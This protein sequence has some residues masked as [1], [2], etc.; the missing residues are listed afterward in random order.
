[1][2]WHANGRVK[3]SGAFA[4]RPDGRSVPHGTWSFWNDRGRIQGRAQYEQGRAGCFVVWDDS[5]EMQTF[6]SK[7]GARSSS[8]CEVAED[9]DASATALQ[10][11]PSVRF[12]EREPRFAL[13][14]GSMR[15]FNKMPVRAD[16][17]MVSNA[18]LGNSARLSAARR[19][20]PIWL[21]VGVEYWSTDQ[22]R[23]WSG[24]LAAL[25][26]WRT[27]SPLRWLDFELTAESGV[28]QYSVLPMIN[29][30][31]LS[32]SE[33][34]RVPYAGGRAGVDIALHRSISL[35]A[36]LFFSRDVARTQVVRYRE[37]E[38]C[39]FCPPECTS[40]GSWRVGGTNAGAGVAVRFSV[41]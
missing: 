17:P 7:I 14:V 8:S 30:L 33:T 9:V 10:Y 13:T 41:D 22:V 34:F 16:D 32:S 5:G 29:R 3:A 23:D 4:I 28:R 27:Q 19:L 21:G 1:M 31:I 20:G 36:S 26:S 35:T 39:V 11:E 12:T 24:S 18:S 25:L 38:V 40:S 37:C 15:A 2:E 6:D